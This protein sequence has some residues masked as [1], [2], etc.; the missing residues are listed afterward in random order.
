ML[1]DVKGLL[2]GKRRRP[3]L[4]LHQDVFET[5]SLLRV[6]PPQ[7]I[8]DVPHLL[9]LVHVPGYIL[10][11]VSDRVGVGGGCGRPVHRQLGGDPAGGRFMVARG[12]P[13]EGG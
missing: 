7:F 12:V 1:E 2:S 4:E 9:P 13:T 6:G 8:S 3:A 5:S 11:Q 10:Q